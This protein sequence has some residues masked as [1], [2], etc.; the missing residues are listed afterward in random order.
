ME[1]DLEM[2]GIFLYPMKMF[3]L[4]PTNVVYT[5]IDPVSN[6]DQIYQTDWLG[7]IGRLGY[8]SDTAYFSNIYEAKQKEAL[9]AVSFYA[10]GPNTT[11]EVYIVEDF[12]DTNDFKN[13][14]LL[15]RGSFEY[16]GYYTVDIDQ[17]IEVNG[18]FAVIVKV[19]TPG[20]KLPVAAEYYKD[21]SWLDQVNINDGEGY[22]S[23]T[24][25]VWDSTEK[26]LNSNVC[27]KAFT[28]IIE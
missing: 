8:G 2:K 4:E 9:S 27:L 7:W 23:L 11:Y 1:Q 17:P 10:T 19:K 16:K 14:K 22:M 26:L 25:T 24:G 18:R 15:K 28:N 6:Y 5:R 3:T 21:V 20:S 12:Q 13:M